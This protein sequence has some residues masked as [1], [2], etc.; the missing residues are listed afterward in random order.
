MDET[1]ISVLLS[2]CQNVAPNL[3]LLLSGLAVYTKALIVALQNLEK[4]FK[5]FVPKCSLW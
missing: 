4:C 1:A 3:L 5:G 2:T